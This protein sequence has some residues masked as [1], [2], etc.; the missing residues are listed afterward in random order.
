MLP[1]FEEKGQLNPFVYEEE[2]FRSFFILR[3]FTGPHLSEEQ[4]IQFK[5]YDISG[6]AAIKAHEAYFRKGRVELEKQ[7][8]IEAGYHIWKP[9]VDNGLNCNFHTR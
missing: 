6:L 7:I 4:K 5:R 3:N 1:A 9:L 8:T 2:L